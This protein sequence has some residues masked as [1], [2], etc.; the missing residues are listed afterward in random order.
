MIAPIYAL[1]PPQAAPSPGMGC[2]APDL[3]IH[4]C[5]EPRQSPCSPPVAIPLLQPLT[6]TTPVEVQI[7]SKSQKIFTF[8]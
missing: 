5:P 7:F 6:W 8:W 2:L 3:P 4:G 1:A